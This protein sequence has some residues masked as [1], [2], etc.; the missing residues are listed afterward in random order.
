MTEIEC[1]ICLC[2]FSFEG[3]HNPLILEC[4]HAHGKS[5]LRAVMAPRTHGAKC[6]QCRREIRR[7][8]DE[9]EPDYVL[10][11]RLGPV[12]ENHVILA[13][14]A[15]ASGVAGEVI[16]SQLISARELRSVGYTASELRSGGY[17]SL[18]LIS[19]GFTVSELRLEWSSQV[20][21]FISAVCSTVERDIIEQYLVK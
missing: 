8:F 6:P 12:A 7:R 17:T 1:S 21:D 20:G 16:L 13:T 19:G 2:E 10:I 5:C 9:L 14:D 11:A 3:E 18:E 4:G 15:V